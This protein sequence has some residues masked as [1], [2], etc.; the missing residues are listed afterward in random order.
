M[1]DPCGG[2][3]LLDSSEFRACLTALKQID[4]E[5]AYLALLTREGIKP[6]SRREK[7]LG[8]NGLGL[9]QRI[10]LLT[11]QVR[12]TVK[13]GSEVIE[14]IFSPTLG[15]MQWYEESFGGT[16]VDKSAYTQRL[17]G[18][19]FGYP[20]CC[21]NQY[22]RA[23]YA[24]NNLTEQDQKILFHWACKGCKVTPALIRAYRNIYEKLTI[25]Y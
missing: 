1:S 10:G 21:V 22:I 8:E 19:L 14:T 24:P 17:E 13:T 7:P 20:P 9:L 4:F 11:R 2:D 16:P 25:D 6:L 12:R 5:L 3:R 23:P 15:Y 18:F